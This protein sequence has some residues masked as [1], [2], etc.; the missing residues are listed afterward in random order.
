MRISLKCENIYPFAK[1]K[2]GVKIG[3]DCWIGAGAI[4]LNGITIGDGAVIGAG[5][6]VTKDIEPYTIVAGNPAHKIKEIQIE[7]NEHTD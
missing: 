5:A 4:I 6:I 1:K 7:N 2:G 3:N